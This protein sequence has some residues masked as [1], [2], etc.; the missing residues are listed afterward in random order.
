M[1]STLNPI[2]NR[3]RRRR[4]GLRRSGATAVEFAMV[5]PAFLIV[6]TICA[7]FARLSIL[8]NLSQN[9]CYETC[10]FILSEGATIADGQTRA[11]SILDRVGTI[12]AD[13][14]INEADGSRDSDGNVIGEL[15]FDNTEVSCEITIRLAD[16]TVILPGA[17]F[18][19]KT[20]NT[21][22]SMRT[23]RYQGFFDA[24][25]AN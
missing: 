14:L 21:Q 24:E 23:E 16:N 8:R 4:N 3:R 1:F 9:A 2:R 11:Q 20:I 25:D 6:I 15:Q 7:E 17:M 12:D 22:M 18:G 13:I 5:A 19:D 10:R